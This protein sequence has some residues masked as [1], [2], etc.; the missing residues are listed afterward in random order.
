MKTAVGCQTSRLY[1]YIQ[2]QGALV[3]ASHAWTWQ[4]IRVNVEYSTKL[5]SLCAFF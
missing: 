4:Q 5:D 3:N 2:G 1:G